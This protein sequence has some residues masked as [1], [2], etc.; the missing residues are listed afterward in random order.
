MGIIN[1][2]L[3]GDIMY[4]YKI[5]NNINQ[6]I[7]IGITNNYKKRWANHGTEDTVISNA[8]KKY[9]K[10]NFTFEVLFENVSIEEIDELEIA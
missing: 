5:T 7:Y 4:L 9:G 1:I 2:G 10:E 6:K 3:W 8:I